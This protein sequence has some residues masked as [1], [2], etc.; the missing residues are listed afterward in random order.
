MS[1]EWSDGNIF[2]PFNSMKALVHAD[3]FEG[4]L[5]KKVLPPIV[6]NFDLTNKCNYNCRFC[7]FSKNRERADCSSQNF[8]NNEELP[9]GYAKTLP[10]LWKEW[11]VKAVCLAGGGEPS[12]HPDFL[13]F[14]KECGKNKLDL[15]VVTNGFN[16]K[17][18]TYKIICEN[19]RFIGFSMDAGRDA[20]YE[21]TKGVKKDYFNVVINNIKGLANYKKKTK[22]KVQI[23]YK[24]LLDEMNYLSIYEAARIASKI[25]INHFQF[26]PA[27]NPN[28]EFFKKHEEIIWEQINDAQKEFEN[29]DF[30]VFGVRHKF[31]P[32]FSKKHNFSKCRA[33]MLTSTWCADGKVY[34]CT[35]SRGNKWSYLCD[36][37]P[38]P[39]KVIKYWGSKEHWNKVNKINF[40]KN[41]DR[42]TLSPY[43]EYF[44][45]I[46]LNDY[47]DKNLI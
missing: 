4:I 15:G 35:D 28:N 33:N 27:I 45:N 44:E 37:Y 32:D 24:F 38:N 31:N 46:F 42:C 10:K 7:M 23:G 18:D 36:H 26:R 22:S 41:C 20:D 21:N 40:N 16:I 8:R 1:K 14:I 13:N 47:M 11:G 39:K 43:N 3:H 17:E 5:N 25:G 19:C 6:I 29:E 34:M 9:I 2:N 12:L 30:K